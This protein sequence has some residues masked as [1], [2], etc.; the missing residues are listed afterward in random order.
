MGS[1]RYHDGMLC[2]RGE[3]KDFES[4][5]SMVALTSA[6][7]L[8]LVLRRMV[9]EIGPWW[10]EDWDRKIGAV[11]RELNGLIDTVVA[12]ESHTRLLHAD[13]ITYYY[14]VFSPFFAHQ[15][16]WTQGLDLEAG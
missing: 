13:N 16:M 5:R 15:L 1:K 12:W 8:P 7:T 2:D 3:K 14:A 6:S 9:Y 10:K 4:H 11:H